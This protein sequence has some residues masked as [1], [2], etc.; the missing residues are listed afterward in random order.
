MPDNYSNLDNNIRGPWL[1]GNFTSE[2]PTENCIYPIISLNNKEYFPPYGNRWGDITKRIMKPCAKKI[3][4]G[5]EKMEIL[6]HE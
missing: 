3:D 4:F 5:S 1:N 6:F 2:W